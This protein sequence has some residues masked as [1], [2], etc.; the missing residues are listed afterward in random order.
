MAE[1]TKKTPEEIRSE[2]L[3]QLKDGP[4]TIAEIS[5]AVN[6]NWLTIEKFMNEL[7]AEEKVIEAMLKEGELFENMPG[8]LK[9]LE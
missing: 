2:I 9:V 5:E 6:S 4:K 7:K 1:K 3:A 8:R